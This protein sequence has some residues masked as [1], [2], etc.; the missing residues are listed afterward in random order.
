[1]A[2]PTPQAAS[3]PEDPEALARARQLWLRARVLADGL[4]AGGHRARRVGQALEF[5]E[6][7]EYVP[8]MDPRGLDWKAIGRSDR[9][10]V[11]RHEL[12]TELPCL[13]VVDLSGDMGTGRGARRAWPPLAGSKAGAA[14]TAAATLAVALSRQGEPVGLE[15]VGGARVSMPPRRGRSAVARVVHALAT[16]APGGEAGLASALRQV[17]R[18]VRRRAVVF[19]LTDGMEEP[20]QWTPS[21][22]TLARRGADVR[23]LH[24]FDRAE[25]SLEGYAA[26]RFYSPEGGAALSVD[27]PG[28]RAAFAAEVSA[29]FGEVYAGVTSAGAVYVP[30]PTDDRL[31]RPLRRAFDAVG[32]RPVWPGG[33]R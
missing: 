5:A 2:D 16:A 8:G 6:Y 31:I 30:M 10:V 12:E 1:M 21:L 7:R 17:G 27:A 13:V 22:G 15:L 3:R 18:R 20:A 23:V 32:E 26:G 19:V 24:V 29:W 14:V 33:A 28:V 9:L 11:R 4:L 25:L